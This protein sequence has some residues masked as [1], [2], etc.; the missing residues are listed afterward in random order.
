MFTYNALDW[1]EGNNATQGGYSDS[2]VIDHRCGAYW[3]G[4]C[5]ANARTGLAGGASTHWCSGSS[6]LRA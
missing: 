6:C 3:I 4:G 5:P 1:G 2:Y